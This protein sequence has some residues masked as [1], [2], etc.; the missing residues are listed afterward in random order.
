M[1]SRG[2]ST[3]CTAFQEI[4][5]TLASAGSTHQLRERAKVA[6]WL[7]CVNVQRRCWLQHQATQAVEAAQV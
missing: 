7:H 5:H 4:F 1:S 2:L 3:N 6:R